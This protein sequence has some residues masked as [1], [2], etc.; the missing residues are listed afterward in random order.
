M[1]I[2]PYRY[3][4]AREADWH[5]SPRP[6]TDAALA[7]GLMHVLVREGWIDRDY[8]ERYT[9]GFEQLPEKVAEW[10]PER[11]AAVTG[12]AAGDIE[13]LARLWWESRPAVLRVGYGLQRHTNGG[14]TVRAIC[15]IPALD[16]PL[17]GPGRRLPALQLRL[18]R[19]QLVRPGAPG[20]DAVPAARGPST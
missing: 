5:L 11:A 17:A 8:V 1:V 20:P 12:I 10:P 3:K 19:P 9:L 16:R 14:S 4:A 18:L 15:M 7:L 6:G 2:D 13:R